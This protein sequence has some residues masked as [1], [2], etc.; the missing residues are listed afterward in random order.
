MSTAISLRNDDREL[1]TWSADMVRQQVQLIQHIMRDVMILDEHYGIIP[2]TSRKV[3]GKEV[4]K[5]TLLKA[6]AEK[7][8]LAFRLAPKFIIERSENGD[9]R[10]IIVTCILTHIPSGQVYGEGVGSCSTRE[11]KYAYRKSER[12]CPIC[13]I[14]AILKSKEK[15]EYFCWRKKDG[16]GA[17]FPLGEPSIEK[18][19]AGRAPNPDLADCWNTVLK[20]ATKRALVA[21]VLVATAASDIFT[22]DLED[23][24]QEKQ[25]NRPAPIDIDKVMAEG[26]AMAK[27]GHGVLKQWFMALPAVAK[28]A[29]KPELDKTWK[30]IATKVDIA[31]AED[32]GGPE[33]ETTEE[34]QD[35]GD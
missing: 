3:D 30:A 4:A 21:A 29:V 28:E 16:C 24:P 18:Q 26:L 19:P 2:G 27:H 11:S 7:L 33:P 1:T 20:M 22:Q 5:P 23:A 12:T 17:T 34:S 9:H 31:A 6:G 14:A 32:A 13:G 15:P 8:C 10:E 25:D 35:N